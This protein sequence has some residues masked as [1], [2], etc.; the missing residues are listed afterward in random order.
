MALV[1][2]DSVELVV[3]LA[4]MR[5]GAVPLPLNPLLPASDLGLSIAEARARVLPSRRSACP[6]P[7]SWSSALPSSRM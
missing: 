6:T 3:F 1:L 4:A 7:P 5:I 2:L